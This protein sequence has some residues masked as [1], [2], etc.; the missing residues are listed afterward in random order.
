MLLLKKEH[1]YKLLVD[2]LYDKCQRIQAENERSVM[3]INT[4][5]KII[6]RRTYDVDLLKRRLDK[7][8]DSW[9]SV[10]MAAPHSKGKLEKHKRV[11]K[12]KGKQA[13]GLG[14]TAGATIG[15]KPRKQRV[16]KQTTEI[17]T[18]T[19]TLTAASQTQ[20]CHGT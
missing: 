19:V 10:P 13:A 15:S 2:K 14:E 12:A 7:H 8:G 16:K 17:T 11:P 18:P 6:R 9:R 3:R 4:L 5:K 1:I 20:Q